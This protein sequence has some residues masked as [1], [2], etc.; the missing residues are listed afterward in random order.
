MSIYCHPYCYYYYL[1][2]RTQAPRGWVHCSCSH[3][4]SLSE[5]ELKP[6][7]V[8][9]Q[10]TCLNTMFHHLPFPDPSLLLPAHLQSQH[11]SSQLSHTSQRCF[12]LFP[13]L[14]FFMFCLPPDRFLLKCISFLS[15]LVNG[16]LS[17]LKSC[18]FWYHHWPSSA[19]FH[20]T[21]KC[22]IPISVWM[23]LYALVVVTSMPCST[24]I[25]VAT[26]ETWI[27]C[28]KVP[29]RSSCLMT[30]FRD[31]G[32]REGSEGGWSRTAKDS[33][34]RLSGRTCVALHTPTA[35]HTECP[36]FICFTYWG[37]CLH[38]SNNKL[39]SS[40]SHYIS[41]TLWE[42]SLMDSVSPAASSSEP[43]QTAHSGQ[44]HRGKTP[45]SAL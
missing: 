12:G 27:L 14:F 37:K 30:V 15:F 16:D 28:L 39:L 26:I 1:R 24:D 31:P 44:V 34:E 3:N 6:T 19:L 8:W 33:W 17:L 25:C 21:S 18:P 11:Q 13:S 20:E 10:D 4:H 7:P 35:L 38:T 43:W 23:D 5:Q 29:Q 36:L 40:L 9:L 41:N 2:K 22:V 42:E 32:F 45:C